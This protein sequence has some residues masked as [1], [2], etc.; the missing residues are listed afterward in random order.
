MFQAN[1]QYAIQNQKP[2]SQQFG[3]SLADTVQ[4]NLL[5]QEVAA[6]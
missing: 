1:A 3:L 4:N 2:L 5:I 6:A